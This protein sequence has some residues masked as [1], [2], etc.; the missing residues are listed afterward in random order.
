MASLSASFF[1]KKPKKIHSKINKKLEGCPQKKGVCE[2]VRTVHPKKPNSANRKIAKVVLSTGVKA[3]VFI[4]GSG[5]NLHDHARVLVRGGKTP[6]L[7]GLHYRMIKG[8]YDL[9]WQE[10]FT[11]LNRRSKFGA[12]K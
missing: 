9:R 4:T 11:R 6:D 7:P 3:L 8:K 1:F 5:H 2:K 10:E 12:P